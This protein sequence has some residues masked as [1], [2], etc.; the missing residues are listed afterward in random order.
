MEIIYYPLDELICRAAAYGNLEHLRYR[1]EHGCT[2]DHGCPLGDLTYLIP[3]LLLS[4]PEYVGKF[5]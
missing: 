5:V 3:T 4:H 2:W 1:H